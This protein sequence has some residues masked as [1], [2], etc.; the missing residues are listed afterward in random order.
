[1]QIEETVSTIIST[2]KNRIT[3]PLG[4]SFCLSWLICNIKVV[5]IVLSPTYIEK[6]FELIEGFYA[7]ENAYWFDAV[8]LEIIFGFL[9]PSVSTYFFIVLYPK[10][11]KE[12]YKLN[13]KNKEEL[14]ALKRE[15]DGELRV[16]EQEYNDLVLR[17]ER[18]DADIIKSK[19]K[20]ET[21][22]QRLKEENDSL[23]KQNSKL[24]ELGHTVKKEKS[25]L[26]KELTSVKGNL[27]DKTE[28]LSFLEER[29]EKQ[30]NNLASLK[31]TY[32]KAI[33][34]NAQ[35]LERIEGLE[36]VIKSSSYKEQT[37]GNKPKKILTPKELLAIDRQD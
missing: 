22:S 14:V 4:G 15:S 12:V 24:M 17:F 23:N 26:E 2:A 9:I 33:T 7:Y 28:N 8:P 27:T 1:M 21:E 3:S 35:L 32:E 36:N 34:K 31:S 37:P 29:F 19:R 5:L 25:D 20:F 10:I 13:L 16:T 18:Q 6:K 11:A 30:S